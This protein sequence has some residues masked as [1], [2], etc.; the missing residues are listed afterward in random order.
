MPTT[1]VGPTVAVYSGM[2][3]PIHLGHLDIIT[4]SRTIFPK[5]VIGVGVNPEKKPFFPLEERVAMVREITQGLDNVEV[6]PFTGLAVQFVRQVGG[7]VI[8]RGLR[9][10]SDM[11]YEF[12]MSL[13]N[14]ALDPGLQTVFLMARVE[15]TH[16]SSTLIRQI[17]A[18]G[19][20]LT[21]FLPPLIL[22]RIQQQL[23]RR[24]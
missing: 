8:I 9:T 1:N 2:F 7:S 11:D 15:F 6:H 24:L 13:T 20:D 18:L 22:E 16:L 12:S 21:R 5:V 14:Q 4:R 23:K 17:A 19:G 10:I 3:D